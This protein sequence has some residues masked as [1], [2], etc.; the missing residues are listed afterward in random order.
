MRV[1]LVISALERLF[2]LTLQSEESVLHALVYS[3]RTTVNLGK[4]MCM[5]C[6]Q[7]VRQQC[8]LAGVGVKKGPWR[9][10]P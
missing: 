3:L 8:K 2:L 7:E 10:R 5:H 1:T 6:L 9:S 4:A